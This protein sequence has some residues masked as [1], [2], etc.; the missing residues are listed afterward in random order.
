MSTMSELFIEVMELIENTQMSF[1]EI[2]NAL[3]IPLEMV[4]DVADELGE[5]D[6]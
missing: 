1:Q 6:E 4:F 3:D 5:F 2:S